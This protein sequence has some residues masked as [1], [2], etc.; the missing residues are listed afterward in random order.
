VGRDR[1]GLRDPESI[2][3]VNKDATEVFWLF[4]RIRSPKDTKVVNVGPADDV[5]I[6]V[7]IEEEK[8]GRGFALAVDG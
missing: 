6:S 1:Q 7:T 8:A 2:P 3:F 4:G 5:F